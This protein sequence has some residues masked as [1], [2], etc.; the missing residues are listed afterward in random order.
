MSK[1]NRKRE[2][3]FADV[4]LSIPSPGHL[5]ASYQED[6]TPQEKAWVDEWLAAAPGT[7]VDEAIEAIPFKETRAFVGR[8]RGAK[9][10]Y[11]LLYPGLRSDVPVEAE[12]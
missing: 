7:A 6:A 10:I 8:V 5:L 9:A 2:C 1:K 12:G 11:N 3:E 4:T